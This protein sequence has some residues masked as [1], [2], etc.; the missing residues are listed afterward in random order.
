[1]HF[2]LL[3][4]AWATGPIYPKFSIAFILLLIV[5]LLVAVAFEDKIDL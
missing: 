1:M 2:D 4:E 5:G 3:K